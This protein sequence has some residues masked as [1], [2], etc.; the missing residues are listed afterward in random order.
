MLV[1]H[2]MMQQRPN[3][4]LDT[5][6]AELLHGSHWRSRSHQGT[7]HSAPQGTHPQAALPVQH[8]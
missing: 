7:A 1:D 4:H 3:R 2:I 8:P 6:A 5:P